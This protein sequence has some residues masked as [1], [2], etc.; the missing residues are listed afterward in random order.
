M[1]IIEDGL[2]L[3][4]QV[5]RNENIGSVELAKKVDWDHNRVEKAIR[6]LKRDKLLEESSLKEASDGQF[7]FLNCSSEGIK[8]I[9][10]DNYYK[11]MYNKEF[12]I[13]FI[14]T[15]NIDTLFKAEIG[16]I[17]KGSFF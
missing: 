1:A 4:A 2:F 11:K 9:E 6:F 15:I 3:L 14:T 16:S 7:Y 13:N 5:Y 10:N 17:F 12:N 8:A